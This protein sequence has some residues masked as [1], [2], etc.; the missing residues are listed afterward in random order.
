MLRLDDRTVHIDR[1]VGIQMRER[2]TTSRTHA[3]AAAARQV[4]DGE[5]K[6]R[7]DWW[8]LTAT[9]QPSVGEE[10]PAEIRRELFR[11]AASELGAK[12]P[13]NK[14]SDEPEPKKDRA[15][16][17]RE[18]VTS[19][20]RVR[21]K[22]TLVLP[23][24][25]LV[26]YDP[27]LIATADGSLPFETMLEPGSYPVVLSIRDG[28]VAAASVIVEEATPERWELALPRGMKSLVPQKYR[29]PG[30]KPGYTFPV[31]SA[32]SCFVDASALEPFDDERLVTRLLQERAMNR[33]HSLPGTDATVAVFRSAN[34]DGSYASYFG[35]C[36]KKVVC[37][38]TDFGL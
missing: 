16:W 20:K 14:K 2:K 37:V 32:T 1:G 23:T 12:A 19:G 15:S 13:S 9:I 25:K 5:C 3:T 34:R 17:L 38:T 33:C 24:G 21:V 22:G 18:L 27:M 6:K 4:F 8:E 36:G 30:E 28:L 10:L 7:H 26:A 35:L 11:S 31:D 29:V